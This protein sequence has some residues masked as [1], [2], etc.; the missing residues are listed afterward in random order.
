MEKYTWEKLQKEQIEWQTANFGEPRAYWCVLG[1]VEEL[2]ELSIAEEDKDVLD[3]IGDVMIYAAGYCSARGWSLSEITSDYRDENGFDSFEQALGQLARAQL[4][5][6]QNIR[7][8]AEEHA[9]KAKLALGAIFY[10]LEVTLQEL[11]INE[12]TEADDPLMAA[13]AAVWTGV[14]SKRDWVKNPKTGV[15]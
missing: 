7:G 13:M 5:A 15:N 1:I 6:E 10:G 8:S 3:A 11:G 12:V 14:V 4:K 9:E 2:G